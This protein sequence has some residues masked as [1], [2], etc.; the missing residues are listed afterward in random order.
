MVAAS[1]PLAVRALPD[2]QPGVS[3]AASSPCPGSPAPARHGAPAPFPAACSSLLSFFPSHEV[4]MARPLLH[5]PPATFLGFFLSSTRSAPPCRPGFLGVLPPLPMATVHYRARRRSSLSV[6]ARA[7][8]L[9][10]PDFSSDCAHL[11][12]A[13]VP[14]SLCSLSR[15][16]SSPR[17]SLPAS[18]HG[19]CASSA[20]L[21][22]V[23]LSACAA[24]SSCHVPS[25][26][27]LAGRASPSRSDP[28]V[29]AQPCVLF[30]PARGCRYSVCLDLRVHRPSR[31][32][33]SITPCFGYRSAQF[34]FDN[35]FRLR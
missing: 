5:L 27:Q 2:L 8:L 18:L 26:L 24:S 9:C 15:P 4:P 21:P 20:E 28:A 29:N 23:L 3:G 30:P 32:P 22:L 35:R 10:A 31:Y 16:W 7:L 13:T 6:A 25:S 14:S 34:L 11:P 33:P 1:P 19:H 17:P 12:A